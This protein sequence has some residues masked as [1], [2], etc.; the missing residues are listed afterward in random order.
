MTGITFSQK[1]TLDLLRNLL[2]LDLFIVEDKTKEQFFNGTYKIGNK[3]YFI[4]KSIKY[5]WPL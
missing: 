3:K 1:K 5:H 4:D 2:G